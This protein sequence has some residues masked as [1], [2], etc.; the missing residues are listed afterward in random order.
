METINNYFQK[1]SSLHK[2]Y[3]EQIESIN[4]II[5]SIQ[6]KINILNNNYDKDPF[7]E[8]KHNIYISRLEKYISIL[9]N[10]KNKKHRYRRTYSRNKKTLTRRHN[11]LLKIYNYN[12]KVSYKFIPNSVLS[13]NYNLI[14]NILNFDSILSIMNQNLK[15]DNKILI[16][17]K[18]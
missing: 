15:K 14:W 2:Y 18:N 13:I 3:I 1:L 6:T 9:I 17:Y 10:Y 11:K 16:I 5:K 12:I 8:Y 7:Y 4:F